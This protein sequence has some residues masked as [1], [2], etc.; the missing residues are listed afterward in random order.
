LGTRAGVGI[1]ES[2]IRRDVDMLRRESFLV[3]L[4]YSC[5]TFV[6]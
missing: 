5:C 1:L 4:S 3:G 6:Y 2:V